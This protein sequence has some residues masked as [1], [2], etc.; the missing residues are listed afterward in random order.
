VRVTGCPQPLGYPQPCYPT[1]VLNV[2]DTKTGT[3]RT[4]LAFPA[5]TIPAATWSPDG[6][7][8]A[9][10]QTADPNPDNRDAVHQIW[11]V[12][13]DGS[14]L[15]QVTTLPRGATYPSWSPDGRKLAFLGR[16]VTQTPSSGGVFDRRYLA[17]IGLDG[18][19][20]KRLTPDEFDIGAPDW[21]R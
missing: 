5:G 1:P 6:S 20:L 21:G 17:T 10:S 11:V 19:G 7:L 14:G 3:T 4:V 12:T 16:G 18:S 8:I 9:F 2:L 15:R 13:P